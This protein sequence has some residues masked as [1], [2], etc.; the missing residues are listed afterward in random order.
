MAN[1]NSELTI[2]P[3]TARADHSSGGQFRILRDGPLWE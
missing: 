2:M 1:W 3:N